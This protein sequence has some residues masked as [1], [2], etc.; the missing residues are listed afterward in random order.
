MPKNI[1]V[2]SDGTGKEG[3]RGNDTN[4]YKLFNMLENRTK[5]Q[6][7]FY[8]RGLGTG[9]RRITGNVA[10]MGISENIRECYR[11]I[12]DHYEAGDHVFL[13]G[14]SRGATTVR[15]LSSFIHL[16]GILPKSRPELIRR[17][18]RIYRTRGKCRRNRRAAAFV[19]RHNTMWC[20][21]RFLGVWDTVAALGIPFKSIDV[22]VDKIRWFRHRFQDLSLSP[23]VEHA[24]HA[25]AID[26]E[27][28]TFHPTLWD[29][30]IADY[31]TMKQVWF[32]GM[33]SDVGGGYRE[34]GLSDI[35]LIWMV[36]EAKEHGLRLYPHHQVK[37]AP[38]PN[39]TMH[40][41]RK[42]FIG[43]LYRQK[44]RSWDSEKRGAPPTVHESV[45]LR[46]RGAYKP[47]ILGEYKEEPW[48][49]EQKSVTR[50]T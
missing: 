7:T 21:I 8:D 39:G 3:G 12:F 40:N 22:V 11:F 49:A 18:Y 34:S 42:G 31:Q 9:W 15:S 41:S 27:R 13:F 45:L 29:E 23:S 26:D 25:L 32:C 16:F 24:R 17:A 50:L 44:E 38:N 19:K 36:S 35:P 43:W 30:A 33:H 47:W 5:N 48:P 1:V 4:V 20:R 2:M 37:V 6:V 28:R 10:G 46:A 14:F